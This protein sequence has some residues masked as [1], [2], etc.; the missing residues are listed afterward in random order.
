MWTSYAVLLI[1]SSIVYVLSDVV[2]WS[3]NLAVCAAIPLYWDHVLVHLTPCRH[4]INYYNI[5]CAFS[6]GLP[7]VIARGAV[8]FPIQI[9]HAVAGGNCKLM[10]LLSDD[11]VL[12]AG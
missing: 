9:V 6:P 10:I 5:A 8:R 2:K 4:G 11:R 3:Y 1:A 12:L 7:E